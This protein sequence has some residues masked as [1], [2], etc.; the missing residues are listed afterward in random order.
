[1]FQAFTRKRGKS[2]YWSNILLMLVKQHQQGTA[3]K[4]T[5]INTFL[6]GIQC[7]GA[8]NEIPVLAG[9]GNW[10]KAGSQVEGAHLIQQ[11]VL[12]VSCA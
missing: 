4:R 9:Q 7:P 10:G 11:M 8:L 1:M 3:A 12:A 6:V 5:K 2:L